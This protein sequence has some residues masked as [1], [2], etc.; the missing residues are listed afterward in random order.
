MIIKISLFLT[1]PTPAS[2]TVELLHYDI[3]NS[4]TDKISDFAQNVTDLTLSSDGSKIYGLTTSGKKA[5]PQLISLK[6]APFEIIHTMPAG[7]KPI[8]IFTLDNNHVV[9]ID[10]GLKR[11]KEGC[12]RLIDMDNNTIIEEA[13]FNGGGYYSWYKEQRTLIVGIGRPTL[14]AF[15]QL[16]GKGKIFKINGTAIKSWE[17]PKPWLNFEYIPEKDLLYVIREKSLDVVNFD[18]DPVTIET[19]YNTYNDGGYIRFYEFMEIPDSNIGLVYC[20]YNNE[21]RFID[22]NENTLIK[23]VNCGRKGRWAIN[24]FFGATA[25]V[26]ITTNPQKSIFYVLNRATQDITVLDRSFNQA[27][28]LTPPEIEKYIGMYQFKKPGS[29]TLV[30]TTKKIYKLNYETNTLEP[31]YDFKTD[32]SY[33]YFYQGKNRLILISDNELL[34]FDVT[35]LNLG[36][37]FDLYSNSIS[38]DSTGSNSQEKKPRYHFIKTL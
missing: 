23:T 9:I 6:Y 21:V 14:G 25:K 20:Y 35:N 19:G 34:V 1:G 11:H 30:T 29:D 38:T 36:N 15:G 4:K 3:A 28:L 18:S 8:E 17:V 31:I 26:N 27:T 16:K 32:T 5:E 24:S 22:L 13:E 2:S 33:T 10:Q 12:I 37:Q 7:E